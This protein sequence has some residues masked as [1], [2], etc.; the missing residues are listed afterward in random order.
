MKEIEKKALRLFKR[1]TCKTARLQPEDGGKYYG[2]YIRNT[3]K[4]KI[5]GN[6]VTR[7]IRQDWLSFNKGSYVLSDAG[8][9]WFTRKNQ[10]EDP[11]LTQHRSL[12]LHQITKPDKTVMIND[13][14]SP[15]AWLRRRKN[16]QGIPLIDEQQFEA[17]ERLRADFT[18]AQLSKRITADWSPAGVVLR[19]RKHGAGSSL[20][21]L[22]DDNAIDAKKRYYD[23]LD[24]LGPELSPV[25]VDICCLL[26]GVE[27]TEKALKLPK[28]SCK[29]VLKIALSQLARH[30]GLGTH[31]RASDP[32]VDRRPDL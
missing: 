20:N 3:R 10:N 23:A 16:S 11:F 14:E 27:E 18:Y 24:Y 26:K 29:I 17:G 25:V 2:L 1:M 9:K 4:E 6:I 32:A 22:P 19:K 28:R 7:L 13:L 15:L 12:R 30:Y 21:I 31:Q 8:R 5:S